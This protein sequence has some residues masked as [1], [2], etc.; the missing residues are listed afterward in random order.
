VTPRVVG[1][2]LSLRATGIADGTTPFLLTSKLRGVERLVELRVRVLQRCVDIYPHTANADLVVIEGYSFN[3]RVGGEHLGELGGVVHVALYEAG[4]PFVEVPPAALKKF[5]TDKGN[6]NK[7][8]M[9]IAASK[10][11]YVGPDDDNC[12]DA[13]WLRQMGLYALGF[14]DVADERL[15]ALH[16]AYRDEAVS[17]VTWPDV[18][19]AGAGAK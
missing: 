2:D 19:R 17:K 5:A 18:V 7:L 14:A 8:A 1:L 12:I 13:W 15:V 11:G 4:I 16:T 6:A 10:A 9:G 3:S